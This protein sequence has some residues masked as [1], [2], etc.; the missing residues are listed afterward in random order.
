MVGSR[1]LPI[2]LA[3]VA[4]IAGDV[5]AHELDA[6]D[7][8]AHARNAHASIESLGTVHFSTSCRDVEREFTRGVALLHSFGY[9]EARRAFEDVAAKDAV[10]AMAYWG[11]AMTY[12]H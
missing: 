1:L 4:L 9:D 10:C 12:Y 8:D 2:V 3:C 5:R 11:I 6:H 7:H